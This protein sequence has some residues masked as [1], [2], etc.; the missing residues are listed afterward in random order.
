MCRAAKTPS[1][2]AQQKAATTPK[3]MNTMAATSWKQRRERLGR[4][5]TFQCPPRSGPE[6]PRNPAATPRGHLPPRLLE[7]CHAGRGAPHPQ[8]GLPWSLLVS[9]GTGA[10][11]TQGARAP[12][13]PPPHSLAD[14]PGPPRARQVFAVANSA[15]TTVIVFHRKAWAQTRAF[16]QDRL[17][18]PRG[19]RCRGTQR[20][21][22]HS[23][24]RGRAGPPQSD[25]CP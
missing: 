5:G 16:L 24:T 4:G 10:A 22:S 19:H 3:L 8:Q 21:P 9:W 13:P 11:G 25:A 6:S 20:A 12:L 15:T 1:T 23:R 2:T 14:E 17:R 7:T 18:G